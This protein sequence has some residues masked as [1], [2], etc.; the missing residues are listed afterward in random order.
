MLAG[1]S[2]NSRM[3]VS[4]LGEFGLIELLTRIVNKSSERKARGGDLLLGIGDDASAWRCKEAIQVATVDALVQDVHFTLETVTWE[5]LGWKALAVNLS[6]IAAMGGTPRYALVSLNVPGETETENVARLYEGMEEL[7]R[8]FAVEIVGGNVT[9]APLLVVTVTVL[10]EVEGD[11]LLTRSS[12]KPGDLIAVTGYLGSSV[13]GLRM[14]REGLK[15]DAETASF[16]REA[17][18]RP[19]PKVREGQILRRQGIKTAIDLSDGLASD[20]LRICEASRVGARVRVDKVPVH[21]LMKAAFK[22]SFTELALSGGEDYELLFTA[23][24]GA[25][26]EVRALMA[27]PITVIGEIVDGKPGQVTFLDE[28]GRVVELGR[29][30]WDHFRR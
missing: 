23:S 13:A 24:G 25:I 30:G 3:K 28:K 18:L 8:E 12:A 17:H 14:L 27:G 2:Y 7:A 15:Y 6:D 1:R 4:Q 11:G 9:D 29:G 10:G 19:R 5:E 20:L 16:L 26:E 21:P 22:E